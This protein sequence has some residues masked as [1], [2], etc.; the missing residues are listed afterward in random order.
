MT[1]SSPTDFASLPLSPATLANLGLM[2]EVAEAVDP[3]GSTRAAV[4]E[5]LLEECRCGGLVTSEKV[6][7]TRHPARGT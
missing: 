3:S 1:V 4:V 6:Q 2:V 5:A 7:M